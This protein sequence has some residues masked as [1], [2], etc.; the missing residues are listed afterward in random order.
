MPKLRFDQFLALF[1]IACLCLIH[2]SQKIVAQEKV[3]Q[4]ISE[5]RLIKMAPLPIFTATN[6]AQLIFSKQEL[7][8]L[9]AQAIYIYDLDSGAVLYEKNAHQP[10]PPASTTKMMTALIADQ[11]F[12]KSRILTID[13]AAFA[14]GNTMKLRKG[15]SISVHNLLTGLLIASANDAAFTLADHHPSGYTGFI[16]QMNQEANKLSLEQTHFENP[17]GLDQAEHYTTARDLAI[18]GKKLLDN[19]FF[20]QLVATKRIQVIDVS[21]KIIHQL[22][23]TNALLDNEPGIKGIKT[24]TTQSAG[25]VLAS[26]LNK[27]GKRIIIVVMGSE[28]R[29]A[30]TKIIIDWLFI[31]Y[32]W[33]E[34][35]ENFY[36]KLV[37]DLQ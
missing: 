30:D 22:Y 34:M 15:E 9:S 17:S 13:Q 24:G 36:N 37:I 3:E 8:N 14:Q 28:D 26:Y 32:R 27:D 19:Y 10:L 5:L 21:G 23:N 18:I 4:T 33:Q 6:S 35:P 29:Y 11:I 25:Q 20:K 31:N 12:D 1:L 16:E 7:D 2:G